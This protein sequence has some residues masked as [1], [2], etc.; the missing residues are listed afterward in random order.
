MSEHERGDQ[1]RP[2]GRARWR[3]PLS[4]AAAAL[5]AAGGIG[6]A[7][8]LA[9][10]PRHSSSPKGVHASAVS[11][12]TSTS[13][14]TTTTPTQPPPAPS[15]F[16]SQLE[17]LYSTLYETQQVMDSKTGEDQA[18]QLPSPSSF[19]QDLGGLTTDQL[20]DLYAATQ[21][22]SDWSQIPSDAQALLQDAQSAPSVPPAGTQASVR[23][24]SSVDQAKRA[25]ALKRRARG[26]RTS[27]AERRPTLAVAHTMQA[28]SPFPPTEPTGSF[29][30]PPSPFVAVPPVAPFVPV[31][32]GFIDTYPY[33]ITS[34]TAEYAAGLAATIASQFATDLPGGLTT[35]VA[36]EGVTVPNTAKFVAGAIAAVL[37]TIQQ[38]FAYTRA[39]DADCAGVNAVNAATNVDN[40]TVQTYALDQQNEQ[41]L[42]NV[43]S[44]VNTISQQV[45]VAQQSLDDQLTLDIQQALA[46]P[47]SAPANVD[48]ELP[49]SAN[50]NL[51]STP[52]GVQEVVTNAFNDAKQAGLPVNAN[53]S[54]YLNDANSA[55][56]AGQYKN[57][58]KYY[59][60]AYQALG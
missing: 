8:A 22:Q 2:R 29:P 31:D 13:G 15:D 43:E 19:S 38:T 40:T 54:T 24:A 32:C 57:A 4:V 14:G 9:H 37:T 33:W 26:V 23:R 30:A 10:A 59:Q 1:E 16:A 35:V 50:G 44:S 12:G 17:S 45:H 56:A 58:W 28:T 21:R 20:A 46:L 41:T 51:N 3:R 6:V 53:A 48:Y 27:H 7:A 18:S 42:A 11:A 34:D 52:I 60:L 55:L 25:G 36:G 49:A 47:T 5:A 39:L